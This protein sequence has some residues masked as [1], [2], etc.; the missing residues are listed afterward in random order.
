M[1]ICTSS[2]NMCSKSTSSISYGNNVISQT[3]NFNSDIGIKSTYTNKEQL[4]RIKNFNSDIG[5]KSTSK[6]IN[7]VTSSISDNKKYYF[8]NSNPKIENNTIPNNS[9]EKIIN[10]LP[11]SQKSQINLPV[12]YINYS[13]NRINKNLSILQ[14]N[15]NNLST[16]QYFVNELR[17]YILFIHDQISFLSRTSNTKNNHFLSLQSTNSSFTNNN[18]NVWKRHNYVEFSYEEKH[19]LIFD[20]TGTVITK[21]GKSIDFSISLDMSNSFAYSSIEEYESIEVLFTDPLVI[22]LDSNPTG[23]SDQFWSFD[24]DSD[25]HLDT[26][27]LL[28]K[29]SAFLVYDKNNDGVIN[30]GSELFGTASGNGFQDLSNYDID[31]NGWIDENDIIYD[32]LK[33]WKKNDSGDDILLTLKEANVGAIFLKNCV[34]NYDIKDNANSSLARIQ[35]SGFYLTEDGAS[36]SIMQIDFAKH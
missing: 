2:V 4:N 24:I 34:T 3:K 27:P 29:G 35:S 31:Q 7:S 16:Q 33:V 6:K 1:R 14:S 25:G 30:D 15:S 18:I 26:I 8:N 11:L 36:N 19:S 22:N 10:F 13:N 32:N 23:V 5:I 20:S 12:T 17:K 9:N 21:D 28:K